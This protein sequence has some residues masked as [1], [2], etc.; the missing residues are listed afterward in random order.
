MVAAVLEAFGGRW[1]GAARVSHPLVNNVAQLVIAL[2]DAVVRINGLL[3]KQLVLDAPT[4]RQRVN[5]VHVH[6]NRQQ[7]DFGVRAH[8]RRERCDAVLA[9][10][11]RRGHTLF[12]AVE[13]KRAVRSAFEQD[14]RCIEAQVCVLLNV[15][16]ELGENRDHARF[17]DVALV[18]K[19]TERAHIGHGPGVG[20]GGGCVVEGGHMEGKKVATMGQ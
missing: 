18:H 15:S 20:V 10:D 8:E 14:N 11:N 17:V 3:F 6:R 5:H 9:I 16:L 13:E 2:L 12:R 1:S 19:R 4:L 7:R